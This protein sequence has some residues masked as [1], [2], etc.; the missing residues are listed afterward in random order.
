[1]EPQPTPDTM[2]DR[3]S[4][5]TATVVRERTKLGNFIRR[6]VRD[7]GEAEDILQDVFYEF[8][9]AYRLPA[10]IEQAS[11]WLFRA[12]RNRII[13]RFRKK[14][15][16]PLSELID[17]GDEADHEY[18][19]D[20]ALPAHDAGPEALY[21]RAAL[22]ETLQDA[23]D[24]LP[25]N[26]RDVF[27]AHELEGCT[28]KDMAAETGVAVNTLLARKRYA[29]LHLRARLQMVYDELDL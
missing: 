19:L 9:Q 25:P 18:R 17:D 20:L 26:Q 24:E 14:K 16:Q 5:I 13:D 10:P 11:A 15:E 28:F 23:L 21:A 3:D 12:A 29:V 8:V 4:D 7:P 22:L 6:R 1:M 27:I 2:K